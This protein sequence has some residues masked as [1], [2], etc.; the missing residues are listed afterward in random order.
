MI[1]FK[2]ILREYSREIPQH[3]HKYFPGMIK[4]KYEEER[5][6]INFEIISTKKATSKDAEQ[7]QTDF[8]KHP[9]GYGFYKFKENKSGK[10]Y[11]YTW[12]CSRSAG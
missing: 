4:G 1:K 6:W 3:Y 7:F 5:S 9:A 2:D 11:I 10:N 8:G 12:S